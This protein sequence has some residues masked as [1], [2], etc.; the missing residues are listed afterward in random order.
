MVMGGQFRTFRCTKEQVVSQLPFSGCCI[1]ASKSQ[2]AQ[3]L[4]SGK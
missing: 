4:L 2:D 1:E 3:G